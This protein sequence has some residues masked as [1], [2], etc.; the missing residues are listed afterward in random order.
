QLVSLGGVMIVSYERADSLIPNT[1]KLQVPR[2]FYFAKQVSVYI[3][4]S[5]SGDE[6]TLDAVLEPPGGAMFPR[7][8]NSGNSTQGGLQTTQFGPMIIDSLIH[9]ETKFM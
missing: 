4:R 6:Y 8:F 2:E 9:E 3:R 7:T 5:K 1:V